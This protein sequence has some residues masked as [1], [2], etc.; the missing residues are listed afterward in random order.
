MWS[1]YA[2]SDEAR[3]NSDPDGARPRFPRKR[4]DEEAVLFEKLRRLKNERSGHLSLV[5]AR[6][7]EI[8]ALLS[9]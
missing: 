9:S 2:G 4:L 7:N 1:L 5:S 8:D 6:R 3:D